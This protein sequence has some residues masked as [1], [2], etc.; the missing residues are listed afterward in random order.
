MA[1]KVMVFNILKSLKNHIKL[2]GGIAVLSMA[3]IWALL[4]FILVPNYEATSQILIE[5]PTADAS[6]AGQVENLADPQVSEAYSAM[7][8][9]RE[10]L[11]SA[12][13][14][15]GSSI[16]PAELYDKVTISNEPYSQVLNITV[17]GKDRREAAEIANALADL[18]VAEAWTLLKVDNLS[19]IS[20][21]SVEEVPSVLEEN[22]LYVLAI[23]G[24]FG[25]I[26]GVLLA[27]IAELFNMLFRTGILE[28]NRKQSKLQ[29]VFK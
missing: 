4:A 7:I 10:V 15:T 27:F 18:S 29:T 14:A 23:G 20:K 24:V 26:V 16:S 3:T 8:K 22:L 21:A 28:R 17:E 2:I 12:I 6:P 9:S 25:S 13:A 19:I 1:E 5:R 11:S